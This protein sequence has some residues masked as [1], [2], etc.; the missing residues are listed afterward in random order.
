[1]GLRLAPPG[2][3]EGLICVEDYR[4]GKELRDGLAGSWD[5][6]GRPDDG[7]ARFRALVMAR[8]PRAS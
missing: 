2:I 8:V 5:L 3:N 6:A 7:R 4:N 1:M